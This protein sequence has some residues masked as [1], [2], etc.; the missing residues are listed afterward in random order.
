MLHQPEW[1]SLGVVMARQH[2]C[3]LGIATPIVD[4]FLRL[5]VI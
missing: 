2:G 1:L 5:I 3:S 4:T